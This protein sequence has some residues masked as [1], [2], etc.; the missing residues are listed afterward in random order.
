MFLETNLL[1]YSLDDAIEAQTINFPSTL[2]QNC[3]NSSQTDHM[4]L[5][6]F[7]KSFMGAIG[8]NK[9]PSCIDGCLQPAMEN[10]IQ[11]VTSHL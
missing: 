5:F 8:R 3:H 10:S 6:S 11:C 7:N 9:A 1:T 2:F 4:T